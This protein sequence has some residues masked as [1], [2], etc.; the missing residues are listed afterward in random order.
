MGAQLGGNVF[1]QAQTGL[2]QGMGAQQAAGA[3]AGQQAFQPMQ[4]GPMTVANTNLDQYTNPMT[5]MVVGNLARDMGKAMQIGSNQLGAAASRANAFGGARHGVAQGTMMQGLGKDFLN[6]AAQMRRQD[7]QTAQQLAQQDVQNRLAA[8]QARLN[9]ASQLA[10]YGTNIANIG[11]AGYGMGRQMT[12]DQFNM[13]L[14]QQAMNQKLMD[15]AQAQYQGYQQAPANQAQLLMSSVGAVPVP[16]TTTQSRQ[17]GLMD[18]LTF[19]ATAGGL[20]G[21]GV[22]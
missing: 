6:T 21:F 12:Q 18:Y 3:V 20:G 4:T 10:G 1:Q 11:Q 16:Q 13:G 7:V 17:L 22:A 9:A 8:N 5:N 19:G 15:Q 14:V 2:A